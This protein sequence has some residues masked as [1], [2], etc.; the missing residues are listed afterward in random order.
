MVI[1]NLTNSNSG[2]LLYFSNSTIHPSE[3]KGGITP[4]IGFH[5]TIDRPES[6][7]RVQP[8]T[9][10]RLIRDTKSVHSQMLNQDDCSIGKVSIGLALVSDLS[11]ISSNNFLFSHKPILV[12]LLLIN[13]S[14]IQKVTQ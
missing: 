8:P 7:K 5:S 3:L 6:V 12:F 14:K 1:S 4:V 11:S 13:R 10:I 9:N 2:M